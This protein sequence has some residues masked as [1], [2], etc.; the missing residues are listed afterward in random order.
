MTSARSMRIFAHA[1]GEGL[2]DLPAVPTAELAGGTPVQHGRS[3]FSAP[4]LG[5]S[6]GVWSST[7]FAR[8]PKV[9]A[10]DEFGLIL[11]GSASIT[12]KN[13][14]VIQ[15][16]AGDAFVIPRGTECAWK[17][18]GRVRKVYVLFADPKSTGKPGGGAVVKLD[19]K[20]KLEP[21]AGPDRALLNG[22]EPR[23]AERT[24]Y[25]DASGQLTV[26]LWSATAYDRK[27][28]PFPRYELMHFLEGQVDL[29]DDAGGAQSFNAGET[30]FVPKGAPLG[31]RAHR[32]VKKIFVIL[33]PKD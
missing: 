24:A 14:Q 33:A 10:A 28:T 8:K 3:Y 11:E 13:G 12:E 23:C 29:P 5:L 15:L 30:V 21:C 7:A 2:D 16:A 27:V 17:Q 22:P 1:R 31:W 20:A 9:Y 25:T 19:T 32:E 6:V 18:D 26:G 4:Q